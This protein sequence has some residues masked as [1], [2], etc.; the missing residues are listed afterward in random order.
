MIHGARYGFLKIVAAPLVIGLFV[1]NPL[2]YKNS[3]QNIISGVIKR[4][5]AK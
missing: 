1:L 2:A 4:C 3:S 5:K